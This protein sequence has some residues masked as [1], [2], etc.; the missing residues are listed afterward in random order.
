MPRVK[1]TAHAAKGAKGKGKGKDKQD[2]TVTPAK[3][4]SGF[5]VNSVASPATHS[6]LKK[7]ISGTEVGPHV[8][9]GD[10]S[11][12]VTTQPKSPGT[13]ITHSGRANSASRELPQSGSSKSHGK[14][15]LNV[16]SGGG[17]GK[18]TPLSARKHVVKSGKRYKPGT[19][20]LKEIKR[21]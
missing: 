18:A 2:P 16:S 15:S 5:S 13:F 12:E 10:D 21:L 19:L 3:M 14:S 17:K 7:S 1:T 20:A 6:K 11:F 8:S 4:N 9:F